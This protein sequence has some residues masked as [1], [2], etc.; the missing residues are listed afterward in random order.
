MKSIVDFDAKFNANGVRF[1]PWIGP[2]YSTGFKGKKLLVLGESHYDTYEDDKGEV[3][4][5]R[6][7]KTYTRKTVEDEVIKRRAGA[8]F[9]Q[10]LEQMLTNEFRINGWP[11]S[12][13][14]SLWRQFAFYNFV[15][16]P[17][18]GGSR[19]PPTWYQFESSNEPFRAIIEC[20]KSERVLVCGHRL[21]SHMKECPPALYKAD[22]IQGYELQ[23]GQVAWCLAIHHPSSAFSWSR[24]HRALC[25]F[26][27][28]PASAASL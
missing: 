21:W 10:N 18:S 27:E 5:H 8:R 28:D 26:L 19:T 17:V 7:G 2:N 3:R 22:H 4:K 25:A 1:L 14:K 16:T 13:G 15:Q 24:W 23:G 20:L 11:P 6:L 9:W 12:G